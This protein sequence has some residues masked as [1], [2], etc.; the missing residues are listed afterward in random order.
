MTE[1]SQTRTMPGETA[2][3][4]TL[5]SVCAPDAS[6]RR[7][8]A[9]G[10]SV[11]QKVLDAVHELYNQGLPVTRESLTRLCGFKVDD[12]VKLLKEQELIWA[13]ERGVYRPVAVHPPA[14]A[15]SKTILPG[16]LVKLEIGDEVLNLTPQENRMLA[17]L[18]A[19]AAAQV[20]ALEGANAVLEMA[21]MVQAM[22]RSNDYKQR[23]GAKATEEGGTP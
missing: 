19:G 13:P 17:E 8:P 5:G 20:A 14:R 23:Q 9:D 3:K 1:I 18:Q 12:Y 4:S 15:I 21:N 7:T 2:P 11:K 16:G 10:P 6:Y 22:F